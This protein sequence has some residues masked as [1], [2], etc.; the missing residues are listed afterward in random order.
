MTSFGDWVQ[1]VFNFNDHQRGKFI[2]R[3]AAAAPEGALV[4]DAGAGPCRHRP[5]FA[6]CDYRAQDFA[7]YEGSD[8]SYGELDYVCDITSIPEANDTFDL[9][10][11]SEVFE[12]IPR[13]DEAVR[14]LA[15]LLK[16]GGMLVLTAPQGSGIH[17]AP[18]HFYGGFSPYWYKHFLQLN[19]LTPTE[20]TANG[21]FFKLYGQESQRFLGLATP[22]SAL[23]RVA[24]FPL[25]V[26]LAAWFRGVMPVVCHLLDPMD[27]RQEFTAG[28]F[29]R[30]T[31]RAAPASA[32]PVEA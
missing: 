11:C 32:P 16:P 21:G 23:G 17:M 19:G 29:V 26:L 4:L 2:A 9:I 22:K 14:E 5:L 3:V 15:R 28:Y 12:H 27:T 10:L 6:H 31:K 24:F 13:P 18:Y 8:H 30:A 25:K 7:K 20:I 1:T